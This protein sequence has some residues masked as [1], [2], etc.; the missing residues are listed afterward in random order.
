MTTYNFS[1]RATDNL[2]AFADRAFDITVNNT[3]IERFV[4]VGQ[5]GLAHS[6]D[7]DAWTYEAGLFGTYCAY[8]NG[9]WAVVSGNNVEMRTS[10]DAIN[11]TTYPATFPAATIKSYNGEMRSI[12]P[13]GGLQFVKYVNGTW[14]AFVVVTIVPT[15]NTY[16][17]H[18]MEYKSDNLTNWTFVTS[19]Y[20]EG[21]A[22]QSSATV[23]DLVYDPIS[24]KQVLV[25]AYYNQSQ[26]YQMLYPRTSAQTDWDVAQSK[27]IT[28]NTPAAIG[29]LVCTNGL[30]CLTSITSVWTSFNA[31]DWIERPVITDNN[32]FISG[33]TYANGRLITRQYFSNFA[34]A[35][36][37]SLDGGRSWQKHGLNSPGQ[38]AN[39][40]NN[41][42]R[43][44]PLA[45][46]GGFLMSSDLGDAGTFTRSLDDGSTPG[47]PANSNYAKIGVFNCFAVRTI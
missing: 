47:A 36:W 27:Y 2:G 28:S 41:Q 1:V 44:N 21:Y 45:S 15:S 16:S 29:K 20:F 26:I 40:P 30:W 11:W 31:R 38:T 46:Y 10:P 5:N 18:V 25:M 24:Q 22:G 37:S 7:G 43:R 6:Q 42:N 23:S 9:Q 32:G 14:H 4:A 33:L 34:V 19:I 39:A 17:H 12:T 3:S 35:F 13:N 8:G